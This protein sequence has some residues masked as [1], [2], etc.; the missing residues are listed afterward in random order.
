V[1]EGLQRD[2]GANAMTWYGWVAAGV[3]SWFIAMFAFAMYAVWK[4]KRDQTRAYVKKMAQQKD[5]TL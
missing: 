2:G 1:G 5:E 3:G 4:D